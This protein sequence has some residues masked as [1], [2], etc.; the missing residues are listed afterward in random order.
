MWFELPHRLSSGLLILLIA[1]LLV[2][3]R[4]VFPPGHRARKAAAAS[5]GIIVLEA[6]LGAGLVLFGLVGNNDSVARA[7]VI[8]VHLTNT[9]LLL[10][11]LTLTAWAGAA[12]ATGRIRPTGWLGAAYGLALIGTAVIGATGAVTALGDTLFPASALSEA[13]RAD[14]SPTAHVLM[15]MRWIH[16]LLAIALAGYLVWLVGHTWERS[17][18]ARRSAGFVLTVLIV[19]TAVGFINVLLLAPIALQVIHLLVADLL[20]IGLV[21]LSATVWSEQGETR[22]NERPRMSEPYEVDARSAAVRAEAPRVSTAGRGSI[23][24]YVAV[25]KPRIISLLLLTTVASMFIAAGGWPGGWL[26]L[27]VMVGGYMSAGAANAINMLLDRDIDGRM[28]RTRRRP[29]V[30]WELAP[31]DVLF[32]AAGLA[33][34]SF[35]ILWWSANL[36]TAALAM[37]GLVH[38]VLVYTIWLKRRSW[39]NIVIGGAAGAVPPLVGWAA[40]TGE[41]QPMAWLLFAIVFLWTPVHFWAL[42]L[43]IKEDYAKAGV[44]MLPVVRG[45]RATTVQIGLYAV[46]TAAVTIVPFLQREVGLLYFATALLLNLVL[47]GR[48]MRLFYRPSPQ[49]ARG[50][51]KYSLAY[52][53]LLFLALAMDRS[54]LVQQAVAVASSYLKTS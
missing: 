7:V 45:E 21:L 35:V 10:G 19:Q 1:V 54:T 18:R 8:A 22:A 28:A 34:G 23:R 17:E 29:T 27:G 48:S 52:L 20:W 41:L 47:L 44:P 36:L 16:P 14:L 39:H 24:A 53:A 38:Y 6:L 26:L 51:F 46:L 11:A 33:V 12:P 50:L 49:S 32:F 40:V 30:T 4:R 2:G 37:V 15:R 31:R 13:V 42:A 9:L 5:M 25:T 43:L 3:S